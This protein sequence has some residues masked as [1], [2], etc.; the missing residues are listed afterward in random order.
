MRIKKI[1]S[2]RILSGYKTKFSGI[3]NKEMYGP[4]LGEISFQ[5]LGVIGLRESDLTTSSK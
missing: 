5:I 4:Q 2:Y 1:I 3:G